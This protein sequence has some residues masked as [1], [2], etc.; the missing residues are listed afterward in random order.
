MSS[1]QKRMNQCM[2]NGQLKG[3]QFVDGLRT[4]I[5]IKSSF[6]S[7]LGFSHISPH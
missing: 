4:G 2:L 5:I 7:G 6:A 3:V 1:L